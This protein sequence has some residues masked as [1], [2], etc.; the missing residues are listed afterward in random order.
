MNRFRKLRYEHG[1]T[2]S[3]LARGSG[4]SR[5][6]LARLEEDNTVPTAPVA[7]ALADY[8]LMTVEQLLDESNGDPVAA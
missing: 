8:Y 1:L 6:T 4:V 7:K 3:E 5:P 2:I